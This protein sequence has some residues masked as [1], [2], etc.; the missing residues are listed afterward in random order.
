MKIYNKI[1]NELTLK[2]PG[3][4]ILVGS[5]RRKKEKYKDIDIL[6]IVDDSSPSFPLHGK[7][8]EEWDNIISF[9]HAKRDQRSL[10]TKNIIRKGKRILSYYR[11]GKQVDIF[12]SFKSEHP[13]AL[14]HY[15]GSKEFNIRVRAHANKLGFKLNQYGLY[16]NDI[17]IN[18]TFKNERELL[19]FLGITYKAPSERIL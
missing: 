19:S 6:L 1:L 17:K 9:D 12:L 7:E 8:G 2:I 4:K 5:I 15:T 11:Y 16:K 14:L 13:F 10:K 18:K 3:K